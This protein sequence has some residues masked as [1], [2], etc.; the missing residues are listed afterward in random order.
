MMRQ[1][2]K[3]VSR[4]QGSRDYIEY[5]EGRIRRKGLDPRFCANFTDHPS[6]LCRIHRPKITIYKKL[7]P[8]GRLACEDCG[9]SPDAPMFKDVV[10]LSIA[11][12]DTLLCCGCTEARLGRPFF[13]EDLRSCPMNGALLYYMARV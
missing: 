12:K 11:K 13:P 1:C 4:R 10:W 6:G 2:K 5:M 7:G 3:S 9:Y 8:Q